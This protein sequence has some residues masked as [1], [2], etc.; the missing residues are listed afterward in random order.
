M[1]HQRNGPAE[2]LCATRRAAEAPRR[3]RSTENASAIHFRNQFL[4]DRDYQVGLG[5]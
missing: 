5:L 3:C 2:T 4:A 1:F